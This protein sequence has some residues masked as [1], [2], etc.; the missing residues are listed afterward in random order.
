MRRAGRIPN[1]IINESIVI[2]FNRRVIR[3]DLGNAH[4]LY[5][6]LRAID[7]DV[8]LYT[9]WAKNCEHGP[10]FGCIAYE[11]IEGISVW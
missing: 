2:C 9:E 3:G 6:W 8:G 7:A 4:L 10:R 11:S 1:T 5:T